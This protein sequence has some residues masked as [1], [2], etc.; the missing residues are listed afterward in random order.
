MHWDR[1]FGTQ[2]TVFRLLWCACL[3]MMTLTLAA[4]ASERVHFA[5]KFSLGETLRYR[6]ESRTNTTGKTTT[7]IANPEGGSKSNQ[8]IRMLVRLDVLDVGRPTTAIAGAVRLRATYEQSSAEIE[9]DS[10][11]PAASSL[12][13]QYARIEGR[14]IEFTIEPSGQLA[15]FH[16]LEDV[17]PDRS[18][19]PPVLSW[20]SGFSSG[21]GFPPNGVAIG[22]KWKNERPVPSAP[23][24]GL[25]WRTESSYLRDE[26]CDSVGGISAS[27]NRAGVSLGECAVILT[28]FEIFR[29][30]ST[31]ANATPEDYVRNGLRTSGT[32]TGSGESLDSISLASG[33][34]V[35]STQTSKQDMD[36][37]ITSAN[38][39]SSIHRVGQVQ[40]QMQITLLLD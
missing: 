22:Q 27:G 28:R 7:P 35:S 24:S 39:G 8:V 9:G 37:I 18:T 33:L 17:F 11:D 10:F 23:L 14:S 25:T 4:M 38:T 31:G 30:G 20:F 5:P 21:S 36:Y 32:W 6:I 12:S 19:A 34:V 16:G 40:N 2:T 1:S 29:R 15:E 3:L 13:E 26:T